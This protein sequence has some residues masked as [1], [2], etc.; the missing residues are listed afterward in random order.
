M[1]VWSK[2]KLNDIC[3]RVVSGGTPLTSKSEYYMNGTVPWLKTGE[4]KKG[5]IRETELKITEQGLSNSS[6]K[7]IPINSVIVAMYGDG[8]TAGNV[9]VNKIPLSTNQACCNLII[10]KGV[11]NYLFIYYYLQGSYNQLVNL[12]FG[13]SQQNLNANTIRNFPVCLP[14]LPIQQKIAAVLAAYDDLIEN[15][16]RRIVLL[17]KMAEE[18]YREWFVR[19]RFPGHETVRVHQGLPE[20]W[21]TLSTED[22]FQFTGGGTPSKEESRY[23]SAGAINWFTPSDITGA[24]GIFLTDSG[25]KCNE[26]GL[27]QSS[28]RLFPAN[29]LMMT[30]RATIGAIGINT[31]PA[32]T[33]QGFVT[34]FPNDEFPL[35]YL[36]FWLKLNK[37]YFESISTGSTF[38]ELTKSKFRMVHILKPPKET[39]KLYLRSSHPIFN[40]I[41]GLQS[42]SMNLR[43]TRDRLLAR[44]LSGSLDVENL[45]IHFPPGMAADE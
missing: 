22:A 7:L 16:T 6:A 35:P 28:A 14:P 21:A 37:E 9:A 31:T 38:L 2:V 30:S 33:N 11:A 17:E 8:D 5:F 45:D 20:G 44:L 26:E 15:N 32:C 12:K 19:L 27:R 34:C 36:Y 25:M 29:S 10:E 13:G 42:E 40:L 4:V 1:K 41:Q 24:D 43:A 39:L 23:W 3:E 18:V